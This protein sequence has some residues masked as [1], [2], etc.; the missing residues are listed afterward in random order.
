MTTTVLLLHAAATLAMGGLIWSVQV[1]HY[2]LFAKVGS[3]AFRDYHAAH[4]RRMTCVVGPLLA[5]EGLS[6]LW[7]VLEPPAPDLS[8][9]TFAG[10]V[11][12][13]VAIGSTAFVQ[14]PLHRRLEG[15]F[16][17]EVIARLVATNWVR[18]VAWSLRGVVA[19]A[20]LRPLLDAAAPGAL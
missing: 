11:L 17:R 14:V 13:L 16:D 4:M 15:G 18:T 5:V 1:V 2:P 20:L 10:G 12:Y 9:W 3:A 19:L 8:P 6:A 7:L